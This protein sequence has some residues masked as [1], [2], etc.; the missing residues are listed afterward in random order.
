MS[1]DLS[2]P[3]NDA[4]L[5]EPILKTGRV[6]YMVASLLAALV[7]WG[8]FAYFT[9]YRFGLGVTGLS[10][11]IFWGVY[12]TNFVF[13]IGISHAGT[14]ISAIL[15]VTQAEWR[16]SITRV[17]ELITVVVLF[18]GV[19]NVL[20]DMGRPDRI[21]YAIRYAH[22]SSPLLWDVMSI[23]LYLTAS[24][25]Y[26]YLPL[27]PDIAYLRDHIGKRNWLYRILA[28]GWD[29][30][31]EQR[32]RLEKGIAFMAILV[33]PVAV[34]VHTVVSYVF[35]MTIQPMWHSAIFGPYFVCG[36]IFSGVAGVIIVM[37]LT[38]KIYHLENYIKPIQFHHLGNLLLAL[39]LLWFYFTL[40]EQVTTLYGNDPVH[41]SVFWSKLTGG[42]APHFWAMVLFCF[43]IP[44]PLLSF[45]KT[46]T[47]TGI[48]VAS[49][50]VQVGMWLER[51]V[52]IVPTLAKQRFA[53]GSPS[54]W[55]SW[56]EWS[57]LVGCF[58]F[59]ILLY[60]TFTKFFPIVSLWEIREGRE[61]AA[62]IV[63]ARVESYMPKTGSLK[64]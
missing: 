15:R 50:S 27:I 6:F 64:D 41:L 54:Y 44:L 29:G 61:R 58:S 12:I 30:N 48:F 33:I 22:F 4:V 37:V 3:K 9:Q 8:G 13:F 11:Q 10:R 25:C 55:P 19:G 26:L 59:F 36:A 23:S 52:I 46:K 32:Q 51:F 24:I 34:S 62:A 1:L 40:G 39:C 38:R 14:F 28:L 63:A 18:F 31:E 49:V 53:M 60:M 21:L 17:A 45:K 47:I 43:V 5:F 56:V 20:I 16:R 7:L 57:I 42:Y 2:N 35:A